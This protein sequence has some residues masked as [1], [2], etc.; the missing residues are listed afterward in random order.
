MGQGHSTSGLMRTGASDAASTDPTQ[1]AADLFNPFSNGFKFSAGQ[2]WVI[3]G[4]LGCKST[5]TGARGVRGGVLDPRPITFYGG[6][7]NWDLML[8]P[9]PPP[10]LRIM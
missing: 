2:G 9:P 10:E 1:I 6:G 8:G 7:I 3:R 4:K 5:I